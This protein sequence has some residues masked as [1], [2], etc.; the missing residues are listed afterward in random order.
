MPL[1]DLPDWKAT[2]SVLHQVVSLLGPIHK[3]LL[4]HR[5]NYLHLT[6]NVRPEG[7]ES[8][9]LPRGGKI[10]LDL[11]EGAVTYRAGGGGMETF[12]IADHTQRSLFEGLLGV[13][14][15][16]GH[17]EGWRGVVVTY[18]DMALQED[19][20]SFVEETALGIFRSLEEVL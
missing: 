15:E 11:K 2:S 5:K 10:H 19:H 13:L 1:P 16:D 8:Q 12:A 4:P 14:V 3:A 18:E 20:E 6:L 9:T 7:L 17:G